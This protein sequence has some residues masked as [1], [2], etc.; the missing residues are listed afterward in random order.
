M[1]NMTQQELTEYNLGRDLD[2]LMNLDPRGYGVCRILYDASHRYAG[3]NVSM[4]FAKKLLETVK[5]GDRVCIISGFRLLPH[6]SPET[7]GIISST[8]LAR[9]LILMGIKPVLV[10]PEQCLEAVRSMAAVCGLH[11]YGDIE[12][13][14]EFP[15]AVAAVPFTTDKAKAKDEAVSILS[16]AAPAA[17]IAIEAPGENELG[18]YHNATGLDLTRFEAKTDALFDLAKEQG[19]PTF[20]VGDLGNEMGMGTLRD[21]LETY[22][23]YAQ[24]GAGKSTCRCGCNGGIIART[25]ADTVLTATV[26]DWGVYAVIAAIAFLKEDPSLMH[27]PEMEK[28]TVT[29]ASRAGMVDMY[30][31]LIPAID[32]MDITILTSLVSL[33]RSCMTN[34]LALRKTCQTWFEKTLELSYFDGAK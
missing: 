29:A 3:G 26:S 9:T 2:E 7:D 12:S 5:E 1:S 30:G 4:H 19:I 33:M 22:I 28:E 21:H 24:K 18:V 16:A 25:A 34:A 13:V 27:T 32:G 11:Y 10:V 31:W 23:P 8:L 20:A 17:V 15:Q 6:G 14:C